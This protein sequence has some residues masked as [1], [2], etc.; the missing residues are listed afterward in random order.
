M[1]ARMIVEVFTNRT[2]EPGSNDDLE[3]FWV[4][5]VHHAF[6]CFRILLLDARWSM[7]NTPSDQD[8]DLVLQG[9]KKSTRSLKNPVRMFVMIRLQ[10]MVSCTK[11]EKHRMRI[12]PCGT[13]LTRNYTLHPR[14]ENFSSQLKHRKMFRVIWKLFVLLH[15]RM[16][17]LGL[18]FRV[19]VVKFSFDL[20]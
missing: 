5:T 2:I 6:L 13:L 3:T 14:L 15:R 18:S 16:E 8:Q 19:C 17:G 11:F 4:H 10:H 7:H 9:T 12:T 20:H 1:T